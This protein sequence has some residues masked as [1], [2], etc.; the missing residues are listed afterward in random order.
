MKETEAMLELED[1]VARF[2]PR[3]TYYD[4]KEAKRFIAWLDRCGFEIVRKDSKCRPTS[5][6]EKKSV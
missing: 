6:N 5:Q 1:A 4:R 3:G 2:F